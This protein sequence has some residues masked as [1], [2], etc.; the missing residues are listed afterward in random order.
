MIKINVEG[1]FTKTMNFLKGYN[2]IPME[3][4]HSYGKK[5]V[6][7]LSSAT[8]KNT[9]ATSKQWSYI[10]KRNKTEISITWTNDSVTK[11]TPIVILLQYGHVTNN[12]GYVTGI[13]F[14]NPAMRDIMTSLSNELWKEVTK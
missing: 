14:I 12:G 9:G 7:D 13:D 2:N 8:P 6:A 3:L 4:L 1:N 5:G 10:I 11:G